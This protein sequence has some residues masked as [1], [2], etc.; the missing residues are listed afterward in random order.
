MKADKRAEKLRSITFSSNLNFWILTRWIYATMGPQHQFKYTGTRLIF[1]KSCIA[2][3]PSLRKICVQIW[4]RIWVRI[5]AS[6]VQLIKLKALPSLGCTRCTLKP[7]L[8]TKTKI[9]MPVQHRPYSREKE[10][11]ISST[12]LTVSPWLSRVSWG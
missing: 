5:W 7:I 9:V 11:S 4:T 1:A 2:L 3:L 10:H 6:Y 12:F 8:W